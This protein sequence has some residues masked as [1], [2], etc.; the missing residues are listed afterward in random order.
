MKNLKH[1]KAILYLTVGVM[2]LNASTLIAQDSLVNGQTIEVKQKVWA[3]IF[4]SYYTT[5]NGD[6]KPKSAFE[7]PT[8]L[9][10]YSATF[11]DKLKATLIYDVTRTTNAIKVTDENGNQLNVSYNEG[12]KYTAFLKMAEIKYSPVNFVD[13]RIGQ[14][15]NTQYLTTQDKFW[16]YRYIYFTYQEVHRYGNPADFGAQIDLKYGDKLLNQLSV[17]NGDGP[18]KNQDQ[19]GK[20]L[21]ANNIEYYPIKGIVLKLY[22]D[23]SPKSDT[24]KL[25]KDKYA[26][27]AF[28]GY[29]TNKFRFAA[30]YNKVIN[31]GYRKNSS[32][33]GFSTFGSYTINTKFDILLRYDY[34]NRSATLNLEKSHL[35]IV[36]VQYQPIKNLLCSINIRNLSP[37][38]RLMIYGNFGITF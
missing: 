23:Y 36:G 33:Y 18:F 29:K 6:Y 37:N 12:S 15:L 3:T 8:A 7:M 30:E 26:I 17:T 21:Y 20:F 19:E 35:I 2:L 25:A 34:I 16:G 31:N 1:M 14:L 32:Y 38:D 5:V 11:S 27:S 24:A 10:G 22:G 9:F 4:A 28:A 13:V